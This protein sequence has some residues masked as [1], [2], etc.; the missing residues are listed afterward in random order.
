MKLTNEEINKIREIRIAKILNID[1]PR[2]RRFIKCP[3]HAEKT[4][5]FILNNNNSFHCFGCGVHGSGAI[6]FTMA[7]GFSFIEACEELI[8]YL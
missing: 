8:K 1:N 3:F 5:S 2:N 6:D 4:A 7:L